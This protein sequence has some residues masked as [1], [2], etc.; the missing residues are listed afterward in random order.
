[1]GADHGCARKMAAMITT[2]RQHPEPHE[3]YAPGCF[4]SVIGK[5]VPWTFKHTEDDPDPRHLGTATVLAV[6]VDADGRGSTWTVEWVSLSP[7]DGAPPEPLS[8]P[9]SFAFRD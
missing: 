1:M 2:F 4:N 5:T 3:R 8:S 9:M 6:E 7:Q